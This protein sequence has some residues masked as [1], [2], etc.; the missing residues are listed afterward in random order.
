MSQFR[1]P[2]TDILVGIEYFSGFWIEAPNSQWRDPVDK[3]DWR[4]NYPGRV[5]LLG[6]TVTQAVVDAEIAAATAYGVDYFAMLWYPRLPGPEGEGVYE[7]LNR[8]LTCLLHSPNAHQMRFMIECVNHDPF[9]IATDDDWKTCCE[10]WV[11]MMR[12]PSC[13]RLDGRPV[14][15]VHGGPQ[16]LRACGGDPQA[17]LARLEVLRTMARRAGLGE[18]LI[19]AGALDSVGAGHWAV[20]S[21]DPARGVFDFAAEYLDLADLPGSEQDYP[22]ALEAQHAVDIRRA[23]ANDLIPYVPFV[24]AGWNPRPWRDPRPA[25]T[26]PTRA[27]W[28]QALEDVAADLEVYP[29]LGIHLPDGTRQ[30]LFTIYAWNEYGEG[31]IVAPSRGDG[32]MKLEEIRAI[33]G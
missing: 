12:H 22:Y 24:C 21:T 16:F 33:F 32:W 11:E 19:G 7:V 17:C 29:G 20:L 5:P 27:E 14:F 9:R 26:F 31:G 13:L 1:S 6:E 2:S 30:K 4:P 15:K 3:H 28:R 23:R 8:G 25:F 18:L 10:I